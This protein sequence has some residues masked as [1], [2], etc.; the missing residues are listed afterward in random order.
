MAAYLIEGEPVFGALF[1]PKQAEFIIGERGEGAY[2][3]EGKVSVNAKYELSG[4]LIRCDYTG[5]EES[6]D[7]GYIIQALIENDIGWQNFGSP[8]DAFATVIREKADGYVSPRM[9]PS[10]FGGYLAMD[11]AGIVVTDS[12]GKALGIGSKNIVAARPGI[13]EQLLELVSGCF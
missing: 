7:F 13:H 1:L 6:K 3:N 12:D 4:A 8:A 9:Y 10:Y 11:E 2:F 5:S